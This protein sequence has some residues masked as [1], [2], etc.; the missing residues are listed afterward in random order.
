MGRTAADLTVSEIATCRRRLRER[1]ERRE[2]VWA[3]RYAHALAV[4]RRAAEL[5]RAEFG[6]T[7]VVL[8]GSCLRAEWFTPWSDVD[9]AAWGIR[10]A[11]TFR[12]MGRVRELDHA[13]EVNLVDAGACSQILLAQ[14]EAEGQ[15]L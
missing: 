1:P 15:P 11:D 9:L 8:F 7:R 10:P 2:A 14:I 12:A 3:D 5:L 4:G 13:V 6:A